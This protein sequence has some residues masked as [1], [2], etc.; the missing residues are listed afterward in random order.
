MGGTENNSA[1]EVLQRVVA[2][3]GR[4]LGTVFSNEG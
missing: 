4:P 3:E 1:P 2:V